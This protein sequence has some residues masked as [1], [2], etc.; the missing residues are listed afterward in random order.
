MQPLPYFATMFV[1]VFILHNIDNIIILTMNSKDIHKIL[2]KSTKID[3]NYISKYY[4]KLNILEIMEIDNIV[5]NKLSHRF[6][7]NLNSFCTSYPEEKMC[8]KVKINKKC[9]C[10]YNITSNSSYIN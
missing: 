3:F 2:L 10:T 6:I 7:L 8:K 4:N 9:L 5:K 1:I